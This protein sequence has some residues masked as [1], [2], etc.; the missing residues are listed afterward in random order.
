MKNFQVKHD[1]CDNI[2]FLKKFSLESSKQ[3]EQDSLFLAGPRIYP[4]VYHRAP[5]PAVLICKGF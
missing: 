4:Q 3:L 5:C 2:I 1:Q